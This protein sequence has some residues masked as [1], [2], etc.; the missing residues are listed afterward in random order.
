ML[1]NLR[2]GFG[3]R[4]VAHWIKEVFPDPVG[5]MRRMTMSAVMMT[6]QVVDGRFSIKG[7]MDGSRVD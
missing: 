1:V 2:V 5:P 6:D 7:E 3:T 4:L